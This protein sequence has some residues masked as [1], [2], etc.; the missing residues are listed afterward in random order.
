M[1]LYLATTLCGSLDHTAFRQGKTCPFMYQVKTEEPTPVSPVPPAHPM[2][3]A[4]PSPPH[5]PPQVPMGMPVFGKVPMVLVC[6]CCKKEVRTETQ[7]ETGLGTWLLALGGCLIF[8]PIAILPFVL[9]DL[10]DTVHVCPL[11][12]K[13]IGL[14]QLVK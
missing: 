11:C 10:K 14:H 6:P 3:A 4:S 8:C 2:A 12:R 9:D 13:E 1:S 5:Y 7:K